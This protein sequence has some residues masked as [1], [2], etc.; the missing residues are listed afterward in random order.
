M[1]SSAIITGGA[2]GLG[3]AMAQELDRR[4]FGLVLID[5][6]FPD[7]FER[8]HFRSNGSKLSLHPL[9]L[10]N[11]QSI[12]RTAQRIANAHPE[13]SILI[14]NAGISSS[15]PF[16]RLSVKEFDAVMQVNFFSAVQM[17]HALLPQ[18]K[19][20]KQARI[21]FISSDFALLGFPGKSSYSASKGALNAFAN[22]LKTEYQGSNIAISIAIPPAMP[23]DIVADGV[24]IGP[25]ERMAEI[26]FL[27]KHGIPTTTVAAKIVPQILK[28][29]FRIRIGWQIRI[30][31]LV[32]RLAP[33]IVHSLIGAFKGTLPFYRN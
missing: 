21:V 26:A 8:Q 6:D 30:L 15:V 23:T 29:K 32:S 22:T 5:R 25:D 16:E 31:D 28:G 33:S 10:A 14:L 9:D 20:A 19:L 17:T 12:Q 2:R 4:G 27:K 3:L 13:A 7:D 24:H 18:L 1:G 11:R